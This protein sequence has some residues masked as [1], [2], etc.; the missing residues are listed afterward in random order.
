[1]RLSSKLRAAQRILKPL[2]RKFA[3]NY[4]ENGGNATQALRDTGKK[5]KND[6][7]IQKEAYRFAHNTNII[8][9][10]DLLCREV[11]NGTIMP[12]FERKAILTEMARTR[13]SSFV[14]KDNSIEISETNLSSPGL[15]KIKTKVRLKGEKPEKITEIELYDPRSAIQTLNDMDGIGGRSLNVEAQTKKNN[16]ITSITVTVKEQSEQLSAEV[17]EFKKKHCP[18]A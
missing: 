10:V 13:H 9:Y 14:G 3:D 17:R 1:M 2:Q 5:Y 4:F 8:I 16:E 6:Q 15:K 12:V 11:S 7:V 18:D